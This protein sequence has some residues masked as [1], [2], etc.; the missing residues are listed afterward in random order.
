VPL[1]ILYVVPALL[2]AAVTW[3]FLASLG[4]NGEPGNNNLTFGLIFLLIGSLVVSLLFLGAKLPGVQAVSKR[5][6]EP[7][8]EFG[9][10]PIF[11]AAA[12]FVAAGLYFIKKYFS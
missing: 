7:W 12:P 8:A 11:G 2:S 4:V 10:M 5:W 1:W 9:Y 6:I 3:S